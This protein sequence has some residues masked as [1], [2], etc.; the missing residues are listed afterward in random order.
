LRRGAGAWNN[1]EAATGTATV[2]GLQDLFVELLIALVLSPSVIFVEV[3]QA[4][5]QINA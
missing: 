4:I 1:F 2:A 5:R 3:P